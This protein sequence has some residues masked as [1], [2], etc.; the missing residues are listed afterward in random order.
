[1]LPDTSRV[2]YRFAETYADIIAI[3]RFLL[4]VGLPMLTKN[5]GY[6][7][8]DVDAVKAMH[9][10]H[11]VVRVVD[12]VGIMAELDGR[13]IGSLGMFYL[14]MECLKDGHGFYGDKW[15]FVFDEFKHTDVGDRLRAEAV[16][17]AETNG[18]FFLPHP[19]LRRRELKEAVH[20]PPAVEAAIA[21]EA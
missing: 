21:M 9:M 5:L 6:T 4:V 2:T 10:V 17:V 7:M 16:S 11:A 15:F 18:T 19:K 1:M 3:H 8:D 12:G 20:V 14:D 13:L